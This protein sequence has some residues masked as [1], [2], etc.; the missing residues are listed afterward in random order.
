MNQINQPANRM[1]FVTYVR[2]VDPDFPTYDNGKPKLNTG[3]LVFYPNGEPVEFQSTAGVMLLVRG[4]P[5][6]NTV[7][8]RKDLLESIETLQDFL[9]H[10]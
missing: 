9:N 4:Y 10:G 6:H 3:S 1:P 5:M 8:V 2:W 7:W